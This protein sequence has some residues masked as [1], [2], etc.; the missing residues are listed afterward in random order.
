MNCEVKTDQSILSV[1]VFPQFD[2]KRTSLIFFT[3]YTNILRIIANALIFYIS[4]CKNI[5]NIHSLNVKDL[6]KFKVK[7]F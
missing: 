5:T 1:L 6:K 3:F 4:V 7:H 2:T